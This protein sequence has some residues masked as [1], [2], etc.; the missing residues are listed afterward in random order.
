MSTIAVDVHRAGTLLRPGELERDIER[1]RTLARLMDAQFEVA[2]VRFGLDALVGLVPVAGDIAAGLLGLYPI[3]IAKKHNLSR[4]TRT[5]MAANLVLDLAVGAI[6]L[7]GDVFDV[8]F[9]SNLK[10]LALL[11]REVEKRKIMK[12]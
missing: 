2:G 10:N 11:E 7:A 12:T 9:K 4:V 6:P 1:V 3:L 5:R 8:A